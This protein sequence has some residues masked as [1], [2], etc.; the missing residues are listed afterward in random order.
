MQEEVEF[1]LESAE[2]SMSN[3]VERLKR[4][5]S[6]VRTGKA[7]SGIFDNLMVSSYGMMMSMKQVANVSVPDARTIW[8][9]PFDKSSLAA[10]E[11][12][13]FE[14]NMGFTPQNNGETIIINV[15]PLTQE[16]RVEFV[17]QCK[18]YLEDAKISIRNARREAITEIKK[19]VKEGY[20]ED[21]GKDAEANADGLAKK[22]TAASEEAL[23]NKEAD[24][25]KV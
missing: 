17:K 23:K 6:K 25:M 3:A 20:P 2:E 19:Y 18:N 5:L 22:Y 4:E 7:S 15:P 12:A 24:I 9:K 13:I 21:A 8:V 14:A 1:T 10:V 16:R 11:K